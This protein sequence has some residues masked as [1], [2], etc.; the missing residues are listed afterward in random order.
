MESCKRCPG[1]D[2]CASENIQPLLEHAYRL[3]QKGLDKME[4]LFAVDDQLEQLV[5]RYTANISA[6]CWNKAAVLALTHIL[7]QADNATETDGAGL[8]SLFRTRLARAVAAFE[9]F[10]WNVKDLDRKAAEIYGRLSDLTSQPPL[11]DRV[12]QRTFRKICS[13]VALGRI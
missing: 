7:A 2:A 3:H 9:A 11:S 12:S 10:P 5:E 8:E 1:A 13:D 6:N 4:I